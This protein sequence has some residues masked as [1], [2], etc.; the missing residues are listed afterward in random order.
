MAQ[1]IIDIPDARVV[2]VR[3]TLCTW[4]DYPNQKIGNETKSDFI[5]RKLATYVKNEFIRAKASIA[6]ISAR[7]SV[8]STEETIAIS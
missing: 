3:D 7:E 6:E 1:V 8:T 5:K 2:E 4:W